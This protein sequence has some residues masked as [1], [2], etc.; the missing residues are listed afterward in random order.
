MD[1]CFAAGEARV[2]DL[3][4]GDYNLKVCGALAEEESW[5]FCVGEFIR[6]LQ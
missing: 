1:D 5:F 4:S 3:E 2:F 6:F